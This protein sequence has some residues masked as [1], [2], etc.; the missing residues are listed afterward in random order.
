[1][2]YLELN[3][4]IST[5]FVTHFVQMPE[6]DGALFS[7]GADIITGSIMLKDEPR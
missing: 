2:I 1:M 3:F 7:L 6:D 4:G 5:L